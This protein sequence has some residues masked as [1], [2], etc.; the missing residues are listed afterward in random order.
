MVLMFFTSSSSGYWKELQ[1]SMCYVG[2]RFPWEYGM[3]VLANDSCSLGLL[4]KACPN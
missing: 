2:L 3:M 4:L 1:S